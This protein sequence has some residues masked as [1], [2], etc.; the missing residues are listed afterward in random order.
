MTLSTACA[1][2]HDDDDDYRPIATDVMIA[3]IAMTAATT[4]MGGT[5]VTIGVMNA[6]V[7]AIVVAIATIVTMTGATIDE[8]IET[9]PLDNATRDPD[10]PPALPLSRRRIVT[11]RFDP[12]FAPH[13]PK[14][15]T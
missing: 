12:S 7:T 9:R 10:G 6:T 13:S 11:I 14:I 2:Y 15:S 1:S 5:I 4:G 8:A 3:T